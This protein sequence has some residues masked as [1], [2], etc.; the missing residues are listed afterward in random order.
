MDIHKGIMIFLLFPPTRWSV[1]N[2][3][4]I[5]RCVSI[6]RMTEST[7]STRQSILS[8]VFFSFCS[9]CYFSTLRF[10]LRG[11]PQFL[12]RVCEIQTWKVSASSGER[13]C[14]IFVHSPSFLSAT[15]HLLE[16][17]EGKTRRL[18]VTEEVLKEDKGPAIGRRRREREREK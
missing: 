15:P 4:I 9:R 3:K 1:L 2:T 5:S 6:R 16:H 14:A 13:S 10:E 18:P 17:P 12:A 11:F 8:I 7:F